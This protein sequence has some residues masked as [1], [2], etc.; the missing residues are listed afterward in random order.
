VLTDVA[1]DASQLI[2]V[3]LYVEVRDLPRHRS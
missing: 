2:K 1:M 3:M